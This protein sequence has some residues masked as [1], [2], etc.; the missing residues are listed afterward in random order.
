MDP[1]HLSKEELEYELHIRGIFNLSNPRTKTSALREALHREL[2][3]TELEPTDSGN[4][5]PS[6]SELQNCSLIYTDI[7]SIAQESGIGKGTLKECNSR[8][9]HLKGRLNRLKVTDSLAEQQVSELQRCTLDAIN[10]IATQ[11]GNVPKPTSSDKRQSLEFPP[12][13]KSPR[14]QASATRSVQLNLNANSPPR[15]QNL[16]N[17]EYRKSNRFVSVPATVG[18]IENGEEEVIRNESLYNLADLTSDDLSEIVNEIQREDVVRR[19]GE[20]TVAPLNRTSSHR[21]L[22]TE[23]G[24][25]VD[26]MTSNSNADQPL[27]SNNRNF[28]MPVLNSNFPNSSNSDRRPINY[29]VRNQYISPNGYNQQRAVQNH[30]ENFHAY[31]IHNERNNNVND[32]RPEVIH[33]PEREPNRN[34]DRSR[35]SIPIYQWRVCFSGDDRGTHLYDF[36]AQVEVLRRSEQ[37]SENELL[38]SVVHLLSGRARMWYHTSYE[39]FQTWSQFVSALKSEF[40]PPN[41][42][43]MLLSDISSRTQKP[44]ETFSE[45][46]MHMQSLFRCLSC[47]ISDRYKLFLVRKNLL[48]K[49]AIGVAPLDIINLHEL[50]EACK[51]IDGALMRNAQFNMPFQNYDRTT[52]RAPVRHND[53]PREVY[54]LDAV[55]EPRENETETCELRNQREGPQARINNLRNPVNMKCWNCAIVGHKFQECEIPRKRFCFRCGTPDY[56]YTNCVRCQGNARRGLG[57]QGYARDPVQPRAQYP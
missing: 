46:M 57:A 27:G 44:H 29:P 9:F 50:N 25:Q 12:K 56:I 48:P 34:Q 6:R 17:L 30:I 33:Q 43:Y 15:Q 13:H 24:A 32:F 19:E 53:R 35:R 41:Y 28:L 23:K 16:T 2:S 31:Q 55:K 4:L 22:S 3:G 20:Q 49:Y 18:D 8:L 7:I 42:D 26:A 37:Y 11:L 52:N 1:L 54:P 10:N 51:R 5:Y 14:S 21:L 38:A 45:Y 40:L 47:P 39:N 36:L